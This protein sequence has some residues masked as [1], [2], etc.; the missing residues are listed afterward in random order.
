MY[1]EIIDGAL[2]YAPNTIV[3]NGKTVCNPTD[4]QLVAAGYYPIRMTESPGENYA[5]TYRFD[6]EEIVQEWVKV[7]EQP[8]TPDQQAITFLR[9][10]A[11]TATTLTDTQALSMPDLPPRSPSCP[12]GAGTHW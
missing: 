12:M 10:I 7:S 11:M 2:Q 5:P 4:E 6:G 1:G 3:A 9:S 8:P